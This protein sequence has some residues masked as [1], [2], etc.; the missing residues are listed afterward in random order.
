MEEK[1][2][3][4]LLFEEKKDPKN[5]KKIILSAIAIVAILIIVLIIWS[6]TRN[7]D[8]QVKE[9]TVVQQQENI[10]DNL[11]DRDNIPSGEEN[12]HQ[13]A[14]EFAKTDTISEDDRFN[15]IIQDI[16]NSDSSNQ[17]AN[18]LG[19]QMTDPQMKEAMAP[20]SHPNPPLPPINDAQMD[21]P[22]M[23]MP[24]DPHH[25]MA[26]DRVPTPD[27]VMKNHAAIPPKHPQPKPIAK[28]A[29]KSKVAPKPVA[30]KKSRPKPHTP[31]KNEKSG[32]IAT[33]GSYLQIGALSNQPNK[34]FIALLKKHSYRT[35]KVEINGKT[36]TKY[37]VGPF[38]NRSEASRYKETHPELNFS[39]Y[40]EV[41]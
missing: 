3:D 39:I 33:K 29:E 13:N 41:K 35:Q 8:H 23:A 21:A 34:D 38:K 11:A 7:N 12:D 2:F 37:L 17:P 15:Q 9:D 20:S 1:D 18:S 32:G 24:Q 36:L 4:E 10:Q 31:H 25:P 40:Y 6:F 26:S 16:H 19:D 28:P 5:V 14:N 27:E 22:D 30:E